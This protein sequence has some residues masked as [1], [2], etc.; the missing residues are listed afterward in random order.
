MAYPFHCNSQIITI[1][2]IVVTIS[3]AEKA[4]SCQCGDVV[5][6]PTIFIVLIYVRVHRTLVCC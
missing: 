4:V 5:V 3:S 6:M 2:T 1:T